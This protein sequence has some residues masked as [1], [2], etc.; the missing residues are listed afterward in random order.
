[1]RKYPKDWTRA[2]R[3]SKYFKAFIFI[4]TRQKVT[5]PE[6]SKE[7]DLSPR[8][9]LRILKAMSEVLPVTFKIKEISEENH[10]R[11]YEFSMMPEWRRRHR[12]L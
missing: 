10:G 4:A 8:Q 7:I 12:F 11:M 2:T 3:T 1:M 6:L 5:A 9:C